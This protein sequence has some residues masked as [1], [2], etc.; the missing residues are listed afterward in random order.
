MTAYNP[1][2]V[3]LNNMLREQIRLVEQFV[4]INQRMYQ[5]Y[6]NGLN[7]NFRYTTLDDT[8]QVSCKHARDSSRVAIDLDWIVRKLINTNLH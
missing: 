1:A 3:A 7:S 2:V 8:Q 5:S 6:S 4:D